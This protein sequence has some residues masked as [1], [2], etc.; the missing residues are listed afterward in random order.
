MQ[1]PELDVLSR[2]R[3]R[4]CISAS[5]LAVSCLVSTWAQTPVG[6]QSP[7]RFTDI[8]KTSGLRSVHASG[9]SGHGYYAEQMGAGAAWFDYDGDGNL[10]V[11]IAGGGTLPGYTGAAPAGSRL[12]RGNGK[13]AFTDVTRAVGLESK[14]YALGVAAADYDN[15]GHTDLY[16]TTLQGNALY[17]NENGDHFVDMTAKA[18]VKVS[19][20]SAGAA[21]FDYDG[22]G[23][24][25]LF[26]SRYMDYAVATDKGC[27]YPSA[28][29]NQPRPAAAGGM[30]ESCG[31][32]DYPPTTNRL[33]HNRGDGTFADVTERSGIG[34]V[35]GHGLGIAVADFNED[36]RPDVFVASDMFPNMLFLNGPDGQFK[37]G[38]LKAGIGVYAGG[39]ALSGMGTDV[40]DYDNDGHADLV[41]TN[42]ENEP[43][44]VYR[45]R[46]D[47]T[48]I[49]ASFSTGVG[50]LGRA[51]VKWGCRFLDLNGDGLKDL[52]V[53]DG[54]VDPRGGR[55]PMF[56]SG[57]TWP[58]MNFAQEAQV[59][60]QQTGGRFVD[61]S[62]ASGPFFREQHAARGA[63]F[64]DV[65]N[66]GDWDALVVSVN[67]PVVLLRNDSP[68]FPWARLALEGD[69][70]N[71]EGIG[72]R[73]RVT[74]GALIQTEYVR[75]ATSYLSDHDRRPLFAL[76]RPG[77]A[78]AEI[79]WPCGAV[80][81]VQLTPGKTLS[82]K[83]T[84]C[85]LNTAKILH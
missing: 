19:A 41:I 39:L 58:G 74:T 35:K 83:E 7:I 17:H 25:D 51:F 77:V 12:F 13:G 85:R 47:G 80:Q 69:R 75:S 71:R 4:L 23:A 76:P 11:F 44:T 73:I 38:A 27:H 66:D 22:D 70:C 9:G 50:N 52:F 78:T 56:P 20:M 54:H 63:A 55:R 68:S 72:A 24:L 14:Q 1:Y 60:L 81:V 45:G 6:S 84:A 29:R 16:V 10:D 53:V 64:A 67:E 62:A 82:V 42:F 37:D 26:V 28:Q 32:L 34:R 49:D 15:D 33:F 40:A 61:V 21:F 31:P 59:Y 8:T 18:G 36:G 2:R 5:L 57:P 46:G 43:S 3:L 30:R 79:R 65:D 48:F